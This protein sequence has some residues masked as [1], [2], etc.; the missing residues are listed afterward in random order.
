M[1]RFRA[2][3]LE[4]LL[5]EIF[6]ACGAPKDIAEY[7]SSALVDSSLKGVDS[8]GIIR[9]PSYVDQIASGWIDPTARPEIE[10]E[11]SSTAVVRG[12]SG[13]GI[14]ALGFAT[15][16]AIRKA[17]AHQVVAVG[18]ID[19]THTGRLGW[20]AEAAARQN[21][22]ALIVGGGGS[23]SP[24]SSVRSV[25]PHGGARPVMATNP[26]AFGLPGGMFGAVVGDFSSSVVAEG[27]LQV[28]RARGEALPP[29]WILDK[30]GKPST[31]VE[32]FYEGGVLLPAA[33]HKGY[34]LAIL[35]ELLGGALLGVP[36]ELNWFV[37]AIDIAAFRPVDEF[38]QASEEFLR[39]VKTVPPAPGFD[40]VMVPGEPEALTAKQR[41]A[42]GIPVADE[43]WQRLQAAAWRVGVNAEAIV[44]P[45]S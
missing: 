16:L 8:H 1:W 28:H 18:L 44:Q 31:R 40:R 6:V 20:F 2:H 35:A 11:T 12:N 30:H 26:Y 34:S 42:E 15:D 17:K 32:D 10:R 29:G 25:A 37:I 5:I 4:R 22:V 33:G 9:V 7:V 43:V 21:V 39:E 36:H 19:A 3:E 23:K 41:A 45:V 38:V 13:F 24:R 27:K 14:L